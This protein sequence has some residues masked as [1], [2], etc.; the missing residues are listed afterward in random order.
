MSGKNGESAF[1]ESCWAIRCVWL[2]YFDVFRKNLLYGLMT[3]LLEPLLYLLS[4]GFGLATMIGAITVMDKP[5]SYR[6]FVLSGMVAQT[7]LFQGFFEAAYGGFIRMYYQR[8]FKAMATTPVT[9]SEVLW[10]ELIWDASKATL[11][12]GMVLA[13]GTVIGDFSPAGALMVLP[14]CFFFA[15]IFAGL[16]LWVS[17]LSRTIEQLAYPQYLLVFPMF[18]FCGVYFPLDKL[19]GFA[20]YIAWCLPLTPVLA[21]VRGFV[22]QVAI[23]WYAPV[24]TLFWVLLL[25]LTSRGA[26]KR[27]LV[28]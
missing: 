3:T 8:I 24:L 27:R 19:P 6:A 16:G 23:P 2:R 25:P 17:S 20:T 4:F 9:L 14:L 5:V 28:K 21:I 10:G 26:M 1:L 12:A 13:I 18:L 11:S 7:V 15:L 22:F